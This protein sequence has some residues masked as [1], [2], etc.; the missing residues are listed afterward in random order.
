MSA[1]RRSFERLRDHARQARETGDYTQAARLERQ[2]AELAGALGLPGERTRALLWEGY[3]LRQAGENDLALAALLQVVGERVATADPADAFG[4]LTTIVH[5]GLERKPLRFC[6]ALLDQARH[7]L[8]EIRRPWTAPLDYLEGELASRRGE[9]TAAWDWHSRAWAGW[10]DEYPRLTPATHLWALCRTAFRRRHLAE[11]ERPSNA[12]VE[13]R[14]NAM[15]ER[16]LVER[17]R[18]LSWRARRATSDS[19]PAPDPTMPVETALALLASAAGGG[20]DFGMRREALR[21]LALMGCW[22]V[23]DESLARHALES[24]CLE[25]ALLLG[26]LAL[27]QARATLGLPMLDDDYGEDTDV[28]SPS[29]DRPDP[30]TRSKL[31][32]A[33][34]HYRSALAL[35]GAED[36]RLETQVLGATV[37]NRLRRLETIAL[38]PAPS[39]KKS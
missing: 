19:L 35:A 10:R 24:D 16:Q 17:A 4:A 5:I 25:S 23:V 8:S 32:Q 36:E 37:R 27:N 2:A 7:Y 3:S 39:L 9:F 13:L 14:P 12:L 21:A 26:D 29:L 33:G 15:L 34:S 6:R 28:A 38:V 31:E 11:L 18:L 22:D 30:E 20:R 1:D